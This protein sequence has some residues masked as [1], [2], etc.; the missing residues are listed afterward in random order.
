MAGS[1]A[2]E[3]G[4]AHSAGA[5]VSGIETSA[6]SSKILQRTS[7]SSPPVEPSAETCVLNQAPSQSAKQRARSKGG[8]ALAPPADHVISQLACEALPLNT[9]SSLARVIATYSRRNSSPSSSRFW[10][11]AANQCGRLG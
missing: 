5:A 8:G 11:R 3:P 2:A 7:S 1:A 6:R 9:S 4:T 10:R